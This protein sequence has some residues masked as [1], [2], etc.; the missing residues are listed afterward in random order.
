MYTERRRSPRQVTVE[1]DE[2]GW[3]RLTTEAKEQAVSVEELVVHAV[4]YFL[5]DVDSGRIARRVPRP[6]SRG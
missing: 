2:F 1:F 5:S 3:R 6:P 4:L